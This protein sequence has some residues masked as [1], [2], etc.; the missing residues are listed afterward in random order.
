MRIRRP[1]PWPRDYQP[2]GGCVEPRD[3]PRVDEEGLTHRTQAF[4]WAFRRLRERG[5]SCED[6]GRIAAG[7]AEELAR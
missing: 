6:A 3:E 5:Y 7:A 4:L 2:S 1:R